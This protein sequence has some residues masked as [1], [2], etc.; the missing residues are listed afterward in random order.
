MRASGTRPQPEKAPA[1]LCSVAGRTGSAPLMNART[2]LRSSSA[3]S[4]SAIRFTQ[5]SYAKFGPAVNTLTCSEASR[6]H[7]AGC[8][9]NATGSMNAARPPV[10]IGIATVITNP[11]SWNSGSQPTAVDR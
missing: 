10:A 6:S 4:W 9:R 5:Y 8:I 7:R 11:M 1:N 2:P 3:R